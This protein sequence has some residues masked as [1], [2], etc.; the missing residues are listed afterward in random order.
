M[1]TSSSRLCK[2]HEA[3][4][5][6]RRRRN[7]SSIHVSPPRSHTL[8]ADPPHTMLQKYD[9]YRTHVRTTR[10]TRALVTFDLEIIHM[11]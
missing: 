5:A 8:P 6:G 1:T 7:R 9:R 11:G 10:A 3:L 2:E 4:D